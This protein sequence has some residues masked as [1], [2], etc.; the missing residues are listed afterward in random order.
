MAL[1]EDNQQL[2]T[3]IN[4][5]DSSGYLIRKISE[6]PSLCPVREF[7]LLIEEK[8]KKDDLRGLSAAA[9]EG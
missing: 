2:I 9:I 6:R 8:S 1:N 3:L 7:E 5:L 4:E